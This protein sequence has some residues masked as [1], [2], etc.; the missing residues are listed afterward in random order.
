MINSPHPQ[1]SD[2][3]SPLALVLYLVS[4]SLFRVAQ[5]TQQQQFLYAIIQQLGVVEL[6]LDLFVEK[7]IS[8][9]RE[10]ICAFQHST[11]KEK[12]CFLPLK[13]ADLGSG[14]NKYKIRSRSVSPFSSGLSS[15]TRTH[16]TSVSNRTRSDL[17]EVIDGL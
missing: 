2:I 6:K 9:S 10:C 17:F 7:C 5:S 1:S 15:C 8:H 14:K 13:R 3:F 12:T 11:T 16:F 4:V